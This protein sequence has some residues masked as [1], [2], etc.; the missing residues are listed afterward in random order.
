[1]VPNNHIIRNKL[2]SSNN[3][4]A[5]IYPF[6]LLHT[7]TYLRTFYWQTFRSAFAIC[8][9][10]GD[11]CNHSQLTLW[12]IITENRYI[13]EIGTYVFLYNYVFCHVCH[14]KWFRY[15]MVRYKDNINYQTA[16][17]L[18]ETDKVLFGGPDCLKILPRQMVVLNVKQHIYFFGREGDPS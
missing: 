5:S 4:I 8:A 18:D 1:M 9:E 7:R 14:F 16:V 2:K 11:I 6:I 17:Y 15:L 10:N 3:G 12:S 13:N